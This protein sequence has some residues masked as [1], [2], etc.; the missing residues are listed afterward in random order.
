MPNAT[1]R[2]YIIALFFITA[3]IGCENQSN[4]SNN[5]NKVDMPTKYDWQ[6]VSEVGGNDVT[7]TKFIYVEPTAFTDE[8]FIKAIIKYIRMDNNYNY[9]LF[10]DNKQLTPLNLPLTDEQMLHFRAR[11]AYNPSSNFE[12][13]AYY[14]VIIEASSPPTM[15]KIVKEY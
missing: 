9:L 1:T 15:K 7:N 11:Y 13:F 3:I 2:R 4:K 5:N 8:D 14:E 10:F 6:L 12:E